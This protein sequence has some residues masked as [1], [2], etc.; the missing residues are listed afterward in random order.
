[1]KKSSTVSH[2]VNSQDL[3]G[4]FSPFTLAL[5]NIRNK[6][7][8]RQD[9]E[10]INLI[11]EE[12]V[13]L[14]YLEHII[15]LSIPLLNND[16]IAAACVQFPIAACWRKNQPKPQIRFAGQFD[17]SNI[18]VTKLTDISN[19]IEKYIITNKK[20]SVKGVK[21][22]RLGNIID[23]FNIAETQY[24]QNLR[25]I[26]GCFT[27][28]WDDAVFYIFLSCQPIE[29]SK[30]CHLN[31]Y[32]HNEVICSI[33]Q[34]KKRNKSVDSLLNSCCG[35]VIEVFRN[36]FLSNNVR[37]DLDRISRE[38]HNVS[39]IIIDEKHI[40][41]QY[42]H[43]IKG[44]PILRETLSNIQEDAVKLVDP[45]TSGSCDTKSFA[46][47]LRRAF[48]MVFVM[49]GLTKV[50]KKDPELC[51][52][53]ML[54]HKQIQFLKNMKSDDLKH[55]IALSKETS[56]TSLV[57]EIKNHDFTNI[58]EPKDFKDIATALINFIGI[59]KGG[60]VIQKKPYLIAEELLRNAI[61]SDYTFQDSSISNLLDYMCKSDL[62]TYV[63]EDAIIKYSQTFLLDEVIKNKNPEIM[64]SMI[65][66][67]FSKLEQCRTINL[68]NAFNSNYKNDNILYPASLNLLES[69]FLHS[70]LYLNPIYKYQV[71]ILL[72][73]FDANFYS[74]HWQTLKGMIE[75]HKDGIF[76]E[77]IGH[78]QN[79]AKQFFD[80]SKN[81]TSLS[82][83]KAAKDFAERISY[84]ALRFC[85]NLDN[86]NETAFRPKIMKDRADCEIIELPDKHKDGT[87]RLPSLSK[88]VHLDK[89]ISNP[90]ISAQR[91][92]KNYINMYLDDFHGVW[93]NAES[94]ADKKNKILLHATKA[95]VAAIMGRNMAHNISS[96]VLSYW[97]N[98]LDNNYIE[99][100]KSK[101]RDKKVS[102]MLDC[103]LSIPSK[104]ISEYFED[105]SFVLA[106][107]ATLIMYLKQR[108]DFI[109]EI[110]TTMPS[111][112]KSFSIADLIS[113]FQ[114][115]FAVLD[116]IT[117][118]EGFCY[119]FDEYKGIGCKN[120]RLIQ[121]LKGTSVKSLRQNNCDD[122]KRLPPKL[123]GNYAKQPE[124]LKIEFEEK[125]N[126]NVSIPHGLVGR[127]AFYSILENFIRNSAKHGGKILRDKIIAA[128]LKNTENIKQSKNSISGA[129]EEPS[130]LIFNINVENAPDNPDY[131]A[132]SI[133]DNVGNCNHILD[134]K[135]GIRVIDKLNSAL[136]DNKYVNDDG[137][138]ERFNWGM[139]EIKISGNFL[140][141]N[142]VSTL[143][144][145]QKPPLAILHCY[146]NCRT[147]KQC[148]MAQN[149]SVSMTIYLRKV[150]EVCII[151]GNGT[152]TD[153]LE[154][155]DQGI[156]CYQL[157]D[158]INKLIKGETISHRFILFYQMNINDT[159][160]FIKKYRDQ[161]PYRM[162][163][164]P[165]EK[166]ISGFNDWMEFYR[167]IIIN[168]LNIDNI[169]SNTQSF[170]SDLYKMYVEGKFGN[171]AM[172]VIRD[173]NV[174]D[175][176]QSSEYT[177]LHRN[178]NSMCNN[179]IV[180]DNH[181]KFM[182]TFYNKSVYYQ[183]TSGS[184]SFGKLI[185]AVPSDDS[186]KILTLIE[187]R[188]S[189]LTKVMIIDERIWKNSQ[190]EEE[191]SEAI[192]NESVE[193]VQY[194]KGMGIT[195]IPVDD[196]RITDEEANKLGDKES[197][198]DIQFIIIHRG[199][200]EKMEKM[201]VH[202]LEKIMKREK[203]PFILIDS[204]RGEPEK[205]ILKDGTRYIAI[206]AIE[207]FIQ[208]GDKYSLVQTLYSVRRMLKN[209]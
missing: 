209:D 83:T 23:K 91:H 196:D 207:Q 43:V 147:K 177:I 1:M 191:T 126:I 64:P 81:I 12:T 130:A 140:R 203:F 11:D 66:H 29:A 159:V 162:V 198:K 197:Y 6:L 102:K 30:Y 135:K 142:D 172:I 145:N 161:I 187:L 51:F 184:T 124:P 189:A 179:I 4:P 73:A 62:A 37:C 163:L 125:E 76:S 113:D 160:A 170:I 206:S 148:K 18:K 55:A 89:N 8:T 171:D 82:K 183:K 10:N 85:P 201:G 151:V 195:I 141:K 131:W 92:W 150:K 176:W 193:Y 71:P 100:Y 77:I 44:Y 52:R 127:H 70:P 144:H 105:Q 84:L 180:F 45:R 205:G 13:D 204:G 165:E 139:K 67:P 199:I 101:E 154:N 117:R 120:E 41:S 79:E 60:Y 174:E 49:P 143:L 118:S 103:I 97:A 61:F 192:I 132:V 40:Q 155:I 129:K 3:I 59:D 123:T 48:S 168:E 156:S 112:E 119:S 164:L 134:K 21:S 68:I 149:Q 186:Q 87:I 24:P 42:D 31:K 19:T 33:A 63:S 166:N 185:E 86:I 16:K 65:N 104:D 39:P 188:E 136:E 46:E 107:S 181:G 128:R 56:L 25:Q 78:E 157:K 202:L 72:C 50:T 9:N 116:N 26:C 158:I 93:R 182:D 173:D 32:L 146:N 99:S 115:Q 69:L 138:V 80:K 54:T 153:K 36:Y 167:P 22:V 35:N 17:R 7:L 122:C 53:Y 96:H 178:C 98:Y 94:A 175:Q 20:S 34:D 137:Q 111:W 38:I 88:A 108:M 57:N 200:I 114:K 95:A 90:S 194:L 133:S 190:R 152:K 169:K 28:H 121:C 74:G 47:K 109:A 75:S 106:E 110:T 15:S 58:Y 2:K 27:S 208:E 14:E 5:Q